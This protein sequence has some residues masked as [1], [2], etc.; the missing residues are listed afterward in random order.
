MKKK[1]NILSCVTTKHF[2][3]SLYSYNIANEII[4]IMKTTTTANMQWKHAAR[5]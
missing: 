5:K 4:I 2:I 3:A 1:S